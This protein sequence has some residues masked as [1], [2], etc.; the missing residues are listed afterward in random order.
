[1]CNTSNLYTISTIKLEIKNK[2][3]DE[4]G[5]LYE[6]GIDEQTKEK[7]RNKGTTAED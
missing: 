1:M 2:M 7:D 4:Y 6:D 5:D 3:E